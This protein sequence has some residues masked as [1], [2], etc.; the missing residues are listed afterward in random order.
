MIRIR[1]D[2]LALASQ[3]GRRRAPHEIAGTIFRPCGHAVQAACVLVSDAQWPCNAPNNDREEARMTTRTTVHQAGCVLWPDVT[4]AAFWRARRRCRR[5]GLARRGLV[6][7]A[8]ARTLI[9]THHHFLSAGLSQRDGELEKTHASCRTSPARELD[10]RKGAV[11]AM[12]QATASGPRMLS[13]PSTP[14]VWFDAGC[15]GGEPD[16]ACRA[17]TMAPR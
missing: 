2:G 11:E 8:P 13:L 15:A 12:D 1:F 10:A 16:R 3:P 9:D 17:T 7:K 5:C 4:R 14:G 6:R